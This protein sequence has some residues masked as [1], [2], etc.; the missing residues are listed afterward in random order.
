MEIDPR[1][2]EA[3]MDLDAVPNNPAMDIDP[4]QADKALQVV[5]LVDITGSMGSQIEG[6]KQMIASFCEIDRPLIDVHIWTYT[7]SPGCHVSPSPKGLKA[8]GLV[9]YTK[10]IQLCRPPDNP[11]VSAGGGDGPE[12]VV[13]GIAA[14][15]EHFD[16]KDNVLCFVVTDAPPHHASYGEGKETKDERKWLVDKGFENTDIFCILCEVIDSLNI[17]FVPVLYSGSENNV[18]Y[19]QAAIMTEGIVLVPKANDSQVLAQ[20]L[21]LLLDTFQKVTVNK[22][23]ELVKNIDIESI[24]KGFS[25]LDINPEDFQM[26]EEDPKNNA[27][28]TKEYKKLDGKDDIMKKILE[29][30][31][32]TVDRFKGKKSAKRCRAV[33]VDHISKSIKFFLMSMLKITNSTLFNQDSFQEIKN[34]L[35]T[36]LRALEAKDQKFGWELKMFLSFVK[37]LDQITGRIQNLQ[38]DIDRENQP[39]ECMVS[40]EKVSESLKGL[41]QVPQSEEDLSA[42]MDLILQLLLVRLMNL[43]FP[44]DANKQPDFADAWSASIKSIEYSS[45]LSASSAL[46]LRSKE[47]CLY[48][49]PVSLSKNNAALVL[50][51]PNDGQLTDI[52][53]SLSYFPSLQGLI[54]SHLVS[55]SFKVFPSITFGL[56]ASVLWYLL[57][58]RNEGFRFA[59][60]EWEFVR[61]LVHSIQSSSQLPAAEIY[62]AAKNSTQ[63]T[64][65]DSIAKVL[66]AVLAYFRRNKVE[67]DKARQILRLV[68]EELSA[69][70]V[71]FEIRRATNDEGKIINCKLPLN[72]D[73]A[74]CFYNSEEVEAF[75]PLSGVHYIEEVCKKGKHLGQDFLLKVADKLVS[76]SGVMQNTIQVFKVFCA[77]LR[78]DLT[79]TTPEEALNSISQDEILN[80]I[81]EGTLGEIFVE[82]LILQKRTGRYK[83]KEDTKEWIRESLDRV[84]SEY[85]HSCVVEII[86]E[87]LR[88]KFNEWT[89]VRTNYCRSQNIAK[90][91]SLEGDSFSSFNTQLSQI[92]TEVSEVVIKLTR[93]DVP[94]CLNHIQSNFGNNSPRANTLGLALMIG[95]WTKGPASQLRSQLSRFIPLFNEENLELIQNEMKKEAVCLRPVEK[96]NRH[97]HDLNHNYPGIVSWTQEYQDHLEVSKKKKRGKKFLK[98]MEEL[99]SY[100]EF[101]SEV[102]KDVINSAVFN[103]NQKELILWC[104]VGHKDV[105]NLKKARLFVDRIKS[106][107]LVSSE[108]QNWE[109][110]TNKLLKRLPLV[111]KPWK[112]L[113]RF[114]NKASKLI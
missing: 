30:F 12:N 34:E 107:I 56:Q 54:Q 73:I 22:N 109:V 75:D 72:K 71:A 66:T 93:L 4:N 26:F 49:A 38:H 108:T 97:G 79:K 9:E 46:S 51:H 8:N 78:C 18:W 11:S 86:K 76:S 69:D 2:N 47:D 14:L 33:N 25:I 110:A 105:K 29:L 94:E 1:P 21:G 88:P 99:K 7:E 50:A 102:E 83:L 114:L 16:G 85:L 35:E 95:D 10:N 19:H 58:V 74:A 52:Y 59:Q 81:P 23:I 68:F 28:I 24:G 37:E 6:V 39:I 112:A 84:P 62:N 104:L 60:Y 65:V 67:S 96:P 63:L 13:A 64:P 32:T 53:K 61:C 55:G 77:I 3:R 80:L 98:H 36:L 31:E 45:I 103:R 48:T 91:N 101:Y 106:T 92:N 87:S 89:L 44:L 90:V 41:N 20:G 113:D 40:L 82:S 100:T 70:V 17:T 111:N 42:W 15:L 27:E 5:F 57:R 43:N